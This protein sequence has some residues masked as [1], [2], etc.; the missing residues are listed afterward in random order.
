MFKKE[1]EN[2][3]IPPLT[4]EEKEKKS[5]AKVN[6]IEGVLVGFVLGIVAALVILWTVYLLIPS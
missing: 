1:V 6:F 5:I 4:Q 2:T 3:Y